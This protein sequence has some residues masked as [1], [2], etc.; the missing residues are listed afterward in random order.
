MK[1]YH[2]NGT[3]E[4]MTFRTWMLNSD[5]VIGEDDF[6]WLKAFD[7][8]I[9]IDRPTH[10][11]ETMGGGTHTVAGKANYTLDTTTDKQRNM[12]MLKYGSDIVLIQEEYVIPNSFGVC[13]LDRIVW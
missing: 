7:I 10:T 11:F 12:L 1:R 13:T 5:F 4:P 3:N 6:K 8:P 2:Y 9:R